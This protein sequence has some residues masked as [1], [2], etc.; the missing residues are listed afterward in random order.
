MPKTV[1]NITNR[2]NFGLI[3]AGESILH[4]RHRVA[5][6]AKCLIEWLGINATRYGRIVRKPDRF[7]P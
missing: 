4:R 5:A 7:E 2:E 1:F 6:S 3:E